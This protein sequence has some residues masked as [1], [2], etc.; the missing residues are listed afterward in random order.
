MVFGGSEFLAMPNDIW[1]GSHRLD[2]KLIQG[3]KA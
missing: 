3:D 2:C 1:S